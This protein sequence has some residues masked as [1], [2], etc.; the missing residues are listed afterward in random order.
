MNLSS[1]NT[2]LR[3]TTFTS[4]SFSDG[5]SNCLFISF[6]FQA[7]NLYRFQD[8]KRNLYTLVDTGVFIISRIEF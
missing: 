4:K 8:L 3:V 2:L 5:L 1:K 6:S 7:K